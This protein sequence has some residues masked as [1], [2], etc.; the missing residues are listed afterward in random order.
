MHIVYNLP[1]GESQGAR[2]T[3][4]Y[5]DKGHPKDEYGTWWAAGQGCP[6]LRGSQGECAYEAD[7]WGVHGSLITSSNTQRVIIFIQAL[8]GGVRYSPKIIA[9]IIEGMSSI[10]AV[11]IETTGLNP[12]EDAIIEIGAVRF[13]GSRVE[14]TWSTLVNPT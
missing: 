1:Q 11:D 13:N 7:G 4:L 14:D 9:G 12:D 3:S 5:A 10:A 6:H 8:Y 2:Q